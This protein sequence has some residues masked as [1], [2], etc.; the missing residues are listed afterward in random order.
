[1]VFFTFF[2]KDRYIVILSQY[3][4]KLLRAA[5]FILFLMTCF[6]LINT[7]L[8]HLIELWAYLV[9]FLKR[10][11][12]GSLNLFGNSLIKRCVGFA[13]IKEGDIGPQPVY[14]FLRLAPSFQ[15]ISCVLFRSAPISK[16]SSKP[17]EML[18][19]LN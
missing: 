13:V 11:P 2:Q 7:H 19:K 16:Y 6:D 17:S 14:C 5:V 10:S 18:L 15:L 8:Y 9:H 4:R 3:S 12:I 1:M